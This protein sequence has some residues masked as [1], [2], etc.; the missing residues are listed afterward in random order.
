MQDVSRFLSIKGLT[1]TPLYPICNALVERWN[2]TLK[3]MLK[4]LCQEKPKQWHRLINPV[5]FAYKEVPQESTGFSPFQLLYGCSV[6][7]PG[8]IL[9]E[10]RT[11]E[12]NIPEV[13][14][15]TELREHLEDSLKLAQEELEKSQKRYK[16]HY[17]RK[18]KP[19]RSEVGDRVLVLLPTNSNKLLMQWRGAYT[20]ESHVGANDYRVKMGSKTKTYHVNMLKKYISREP[21]GNVVTVDAT[22]GATVAVYCSRRIV[23]SC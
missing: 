23:I 6:R 18:A 14:S 16:R 15:S 5:L 3:S 21:E 22:D 20:V 7:G 10:L 2:G 1:S 13:K 8:M 9:K 4:R 12:V 11:K 17:D 19:R